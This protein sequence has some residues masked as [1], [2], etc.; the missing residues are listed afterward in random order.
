MKTA[1]AKVELERAPER[2]APLVPLVEFRHRSWMEP[3]ERADTFAFLE[4]NGARV[5]LAWTRR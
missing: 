4:R 1:A 3:D 5:R 2:V